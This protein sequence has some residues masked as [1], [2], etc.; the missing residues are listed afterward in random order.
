MTGNPFAIGCLVHNGPRYRA[1]IHAAPCH[2]KEYR[3][4]YSIQ[5]LRYLEDDK[6]RGLTKALRTLGDAS[7]EAEVHRLRTLAASENQIVEGIRQMENDLF[8][9][10]LR[11]RECEQ[12]LE[13]ADAVRRLQEA[14]EKDQGI[15]RVSA[16]E[17]ERESHTISRREGDP[18]W[19]VTRPRGR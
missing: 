12:R 8:Y 14:E 4:Q 6:Y 16:W 15:I 9:A 13:D 7:L 11:K 10:R 1:E 18:H 17:V 2:D 19:A 5:Q 3:P